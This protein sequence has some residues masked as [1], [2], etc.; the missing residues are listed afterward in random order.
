MKSKKIFFGGEYL[1]TDDTLQ[2][3][4]KTNLDKAL[5]GAFTVEDAKIEE[6]EVSIKINRHIKNFYQAQPG[7]ISLDDAVVLCGQLQKAEK[8]IPLPLH[9]FCD[10]MNY[11]FDLDDIKEGYNQIMGKGDKLKAMEAISD[12]L[13]VTYTYK[14]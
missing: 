10:I 8:H 2:S 7:F 9:P 5:P 4:I 3:N 11:H 1:S 6:N 13:S 12:P 14:F